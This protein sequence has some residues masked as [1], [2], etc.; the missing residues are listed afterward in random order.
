MMT[1]ILQS[2]MD[3]PKFVNCMSQSEPFYYPTAPLVLTCQAVAE[4]M[5]AQADLTH[6]N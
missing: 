2:P 1:K 3:G 5:T 4:V 6:G